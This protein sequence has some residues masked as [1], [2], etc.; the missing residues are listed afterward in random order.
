VIADGGEC[1]EAYTGGELVSDLP[2]YLEAESGLAD[3]A[4]TRERQETYVRM[5]QSLA[6]LLHFSLATDERSEL[7]E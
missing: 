3:P 5:Q 7:R 2:C 4:G 6:H 1:D